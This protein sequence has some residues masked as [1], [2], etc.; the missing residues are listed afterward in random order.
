MVEVVVNTVGYCP[1]C[2]DGREA[3]TA[4]FSQSGVSTYIKISFLLTGK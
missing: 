4:G 2:K 3:F 1:V